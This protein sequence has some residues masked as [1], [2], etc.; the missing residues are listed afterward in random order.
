MLSELLQAYRSVRERR[1]KER[2]FN[3]LQA[4]PLN[5]PILRDLINTAQH[6]VVVNVMLADGTKLEIRR[7]DAFDRMQAQRHR[8]IRMADGTEVLAEELW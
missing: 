3:R 5:Y 1:R 2:E 7:A 8:K 4:T 6:D